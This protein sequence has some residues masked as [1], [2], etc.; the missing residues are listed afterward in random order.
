MITGADPVA[1]LSPTPKPGVAAAMRRIY[2]P[3]PVTG[4]WGQWSLQSNVAFGKAKGAIRKWRAGLAEGSWP[5][6]L[7]LGLP[8]DRQHECRLFYLDEDYVA[9]AKA[10]AA[11]GGEVE[12]VSTNDVVASWFSRNLGVATM[13]INFRGRLEDALDTDAGNYVSSL[14]FG[15]ADSARPALI[16]W[17]LQNGFRRAAADT[18]P[19][20]AGLG[21]MGRTTGLLTS[22]A[23]FAK[24]PRLPG[25]ELE[26]T[27]PYG[28]MDRD[29][30]DPLKHN[31][32]VPVGIVFRANDRLAMSVAG[33][34]EV[35]ERFEWT[36]SLPGE[37]LDIHAHWRAIL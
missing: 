7:G 3:G 35:L 8:A 9:R 30:S 10:D 16:R 4:V 27:F 15:P 29:S 17:T 34:P 37:A 22:W 1:A 11:A 20:P 25:A 14:P 26:L 28:D 21:W 13:A 32:A 33:F 31:F 19:L 2:A 36:G 5:A 18:S 6:R 12:Y 24:P 23:S